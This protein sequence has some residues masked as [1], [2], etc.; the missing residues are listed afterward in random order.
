M[1]AGTGTL[2]QLVTS[3]ITRFAAEL[4]A[5]IVQTGEDA[6]RAADRGYIALAGD[7]RGRLARLER[8]AAIVSE[9][10]KARPNGKNEISTA[11]RIA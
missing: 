10:L 1:S 4:R 8:L 5:E 6:R 2:T 9:L 3:E 11:R 7:L